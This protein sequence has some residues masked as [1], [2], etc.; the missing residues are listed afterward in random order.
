TAPPGESTTGP[1]WKPLEARQRRVLGVLI[2]KA[3]TTPAGY[4][5][6]V[7][8]IVTGCNQK[9]N[10][11]PV[12]AYDDIDVE[13]ALDELRILGAVSEVDWVGRVSKYKH[14][15]YEWLGVNRAELAVM[16]ELLLR[17]AQAMGELRARAA[18]MED[19][20][21]LAALK[22]IVDGLIERGLMI[23]LSPA[24][25]GQIVTHHLYTPSELA[26]LKAGHSGTR[27]PAAEHAPAV[28]AA[29]VAGEAPSP[30]RPPSPAAA[31]GDRAAA[32]AAEVAELRA[33]LSR[34]RE[35]VDPRE[36][37]PRGP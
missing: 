18:R 2:E 28:H 25:R 29:A 37:W 33:E 10:R 6:T 13:K 20:A 15:A 26:E 36:G 14:H 31:S 8:A 23:E 21:D 34:L 22:P 30:P 7:N 11:D 16:A 17:G 3:K 4:P 27:V 9:N 12:T 32:L 19:I 24:G 35:R 5:M 1:R